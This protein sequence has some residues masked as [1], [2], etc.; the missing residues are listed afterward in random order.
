MIK[1]LSLGA[2]V[3]SSTIFMMACFDEIERP[4]HVIFA[5]TGWEPKPVYRWLEYLKEQGEKYGMKIHTVSQG[6]I[7]NDALV[8]QIRG[9]SKD[10][11]R[12]ASMPLFIKK[13]W[14]KTDIPILTQLIKDDD[15]GKYKPI[16]ETVKLNKPYIQKGMIRRQCTYEYKLRPLLKKQ[17][18]LAGYKKY[19]R[20]PP[21][22]IECWKGISIDEQ[23]RAT[24]SDKKW[25]SFYY[26]LIEMRMRR[27]DCV[28]WWRKRDL[29]TPPRSACVGCPFRHNSEWA[30]LK[31]NSPEDFK[32]AVFVDRMIRECGG[33]RGEV[34]LHADRI[35][36]DEVKFN[37]D[38]KQLS[39]FDNE[40][41]GICGV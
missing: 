24:V 1:I 27:S 22:T 36:L 41:A 25:L 33:M 39:L 18:E 37:K 17:R 40:C 16:L 9:V 10:G 4:D 21:G 7:R 23:K 13:V 8:S 2:G 35:P 34:F 5:D 31:E 32:D 3:Q 14:T 12:F 15:D 6:N 28:A 26:P 30:W 29:P 38:E 11:K 20:I 19:A